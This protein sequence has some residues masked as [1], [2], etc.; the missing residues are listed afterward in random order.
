MG[1]SVGVVR[2]MDG[3]DGVISLIRRTGRR[4]RKGWVVFGDEKGRFWTCYGPGDDDTVR[5]RPKLQNDP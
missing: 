4:D 2:V 3:S 5:G 1:G